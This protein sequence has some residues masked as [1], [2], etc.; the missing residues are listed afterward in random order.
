M[1]P[2]TDR[3]ICLY[4]VQDD[5][6]HLADFGQTDMMH[7]W[8]APGHAALYALQA[9]DSWWGQPSHQGSDEDVDAQ[10]VVLWGPRRDAAVCDDLLSALADPLR[11]L[12]EA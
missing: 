12:Q 4:L 6:W 7:W 9:G 8:V 5:R 10:Q 3:Q 11:V 2:D 1:A